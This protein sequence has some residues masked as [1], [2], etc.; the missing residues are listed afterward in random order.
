MLFLL[1]SILLLTGCQQREGVPKAV[2]GVID[3][4]GWNFEKNG[5][6]RL[7]GEWSFYWSKLLEPKD[8]NSAVS[9]P[10]STLLFVPGSWN[11]NLYNKNHFPP[12]G[13]ATYRLIIKHVNSGSPFTLW[14]GN[15]ATSYKLWIDGKQLMSNGIVGKCKKE[16][17]PQFFPQSITYIP[18]SN[19]LQLIIQVSS[20][21]FSQGGLT[22]DVL[23]GYP[24]QIQ[25]KERSIIAEDMFLFGSLL[26]MGLYHLILFI[27]RRNDYSTLYFGILCILIS[28][29]TIFSGNMIISY[30]LVNITPEIIIKVFYMAGALSVVIFVMFLNAVF[31]DSLNKSFIHFSAI[32]SSIFCI[33]FLLFSEKNIYNFMLIFEII[34]I[35]ILLYILYFLIK[36]MVAKKE[37]SVLVTIGVSIL[38]LFSIIDAMI[39]IGLINISRILPLGIFIFVFVQS[40]M[41]AEKFA[42]QERLLHKAEIMALRAQINPHFLFNALNSIYSLFRSNPEKGRK[43]LFELSNYLRGSFSFKEP[44]EFITLS[45]E[46]DHIRSYLSIEEARFNSRLKVLY[47]MEEADNFKIPSLIL[48]PIVENAIKHGISPKI[49]GGTLKISIKTRD[50]Y[51]NCVIEDNGVGMTENK[52]KDILNGADKSAGIGISNVNKRLKKIYN[53]GLMIKSIEGEGTKVTICIPLKQ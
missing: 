13:Y 35:I 32:S 9:S 1:L 14:M 12:E 53:A 52:V 33:I 19:T 2:G 22:N 46:L 34:E 45:K 11:R 38:L 5:L 6:I 25:R 30:Y 17:T 7:G 41:L 26:I 43:L 42:K 21:G 44:E 48:Q 16:Y 36:C 47:D 39:S 50:K 10:N 3:L 20:F 23:F 37:N 51:L 8:F 29:L 49:E 4:S 28:V 40:F 15:S 24:Y 18:Q 31:P 27:R